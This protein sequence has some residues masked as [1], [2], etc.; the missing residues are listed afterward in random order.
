MPLLHRENLEAQLYPLS[1]LAL[2]GGA[3]SMPLSSH[4]TAG[5]EIQYPL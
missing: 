1:L 5:T 4:F 2:E 3:W